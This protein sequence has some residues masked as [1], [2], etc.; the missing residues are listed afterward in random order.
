M[1]I[2]LPTPSVIPFAPFDPVMGCSVEFQY[3]GNQ[4]KKNRV[5]ITNNTTNQ[6][7]YDEPQTTNACRHVIPANSALE[8]ELN[9]GYC[10]YELQVQVF[11]EEGNS[12]NLSAP[13]LFY[14]LTTPTFA[15][16]N[17][18][19]GQTYRSA[20]IDLAITYSQAQGE[21]LRS[22]QF[23]KYAYDKTRL[24]QSTVSYT[25]TT[26]T[27]TGLDDNQTYYFRAIGETTH[28]I[29]LDTGYVAVN[30]VYDVLP[31]NLLLKVENKYSEGYIQLTSGIRNIAYELYND[32][33]TLED[34]VLI[35]RDNTL[36]YKDFD[37]NN[38]VSGNFT[39]FV[40]ARKLPLQEFLT[41]N[42]NAFSLS[43]VDICGEYYCQ[44]A[45]KDSDFSMYMPITKAQRSTGSLT[46]TNG[47]AL[48][49]VA[50]VDDAVIFEVKRVDWH[51]NLSVYYRSE[52]TT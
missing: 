43:I 23:F 48:A 34:D 35:L 5:V 18:T 3:T 50:I 8:A 45:V 10:K 27:F 38:N 51:Y 37:A 21:S 46:L 36:V 32:N 20:T 25:E 12:S 15:F 22:V 4:P 44:L 47:E 24:S 2:I 17:I 7:V 19:E 11:D 14:C 33:Y 52:I 49:M 29:A 42:D 39:L 9:S 6:V 31:A 13:V 30:I 16:A 40:E 28:G 1:S 41:T 26:H